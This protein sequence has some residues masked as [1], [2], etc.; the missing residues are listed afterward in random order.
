MCLARVLA[1]SQAASVRVQRVA[2]NV[3][4]L[5]APPHDWD[6]PIMPIIPARVPE[7][8]P[9]MVCPSSDIMPSPSIT[10][11]QAA[12]IPVKLPDGIS[13]WKLNARPLTV[14]R[15]VPFPIMLRVSSLIFIVPVRPVP[16]WL[17]VH[18]SLAWPVLSIEVPVH[19]PVMLLELGVVTIDGEVGDDE[20]PPQAEVSNPAS[21]IHVADFTLTLLAGPS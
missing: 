9:V 5:M 21:T 12:I 6:D 8:V 7:Y 11:E 1:D 15:M 13:M 19:V 18:T 4:L 16:T 20:L 2:V 10:I 3:P 14:P 17:T